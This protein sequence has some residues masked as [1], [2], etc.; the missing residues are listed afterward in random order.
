MLWLEG[1]TTS[2][3]GGS[4]GSGIPEILG[5]LLVAWGGLIWV[6]KILQSPLV[7]DDESW[8]NWIRRMTGSTFF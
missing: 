1:R 4:S 5:V 7:V 8:E 2:T 3:K 6:I